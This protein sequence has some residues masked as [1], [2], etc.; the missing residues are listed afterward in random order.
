MG[1]NSVHPK[2]LLKHNEIPPS[3]L[4]I[5]HNAGCCGMNVIP[6]KHLGSTDNVKNMFGFTDEHFP[7]CAFMA[8]RAPV[9]TGQTPD[10]V[11]MFPKTFSEHDARFG[12]K[13]PLVS[14]GGNWGENTKSTG[15]MGRWAMGATE[16]GQPAYF[17]SMQSL[18]DY[19][20]LPHKE[21]IAVCLTHDPKDYRIGYRTDGLNTIGRV[22]VAFIGGYG[23]LTELSCVLTTISISQFYASKVIIVS[24]L[25]ENPRTGKTTRF[26]AKLAPLIEEYVDFNT[27]GPEATK[28]ILEQCIY[29]QPAKDAPARVMTRDLTSLVMMAR[30]EAL[31]SALY[32]HLQPLSP[33]ARSTLINP[34]S[35]G[36][37]LAPFL[38]ADYG[39][40]DWLNKLSRQLSCPT[41]R[42]PYQDCT[43]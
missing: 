36:S 14:G 30:E 31:H 18:V 32:P 1:S 34:L 12:L 11:E 2:G 40:S 5:I 29:Y 43:P 35:S 4:N 42:S 9:A 3:L 20:G 17:L 25:L 24:P 15:L 26:H 7:V 37:Q 8:G 38:S 16:V 21:G 28:R 13:M 41:V 6:A 39:Q 19:E 33:H 22:F 23:T 27:A 10:L